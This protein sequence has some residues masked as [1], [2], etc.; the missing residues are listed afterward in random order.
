MKRAAVTPAERDAMVAALATQSDREVAA[1]FGRSVSFVRQLRGVR[2]MDGS[3][4]VVRG[5]GAGRT[6]AHFKAAAKRR[7]DLEHD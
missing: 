4:V 3:P 6:E 5:H 7:R 2:N 1:A